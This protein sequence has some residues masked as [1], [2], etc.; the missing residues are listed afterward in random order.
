MFDA[1]LEDLIAKAAKRGEGGLP[2]ISIDSTTAS[3]HHQR[4][5]EA[6]I[7]EK[8]DHAANRKRKVPGVAGPSATTLTSARRGTP[9]NGR[10]TSSRHG[11]ASPLG[12]TRPRTD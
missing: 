4:H 10:S 6:V 11:G 8:G 1:L 2:L 5:I 9:S 12:T 3:A 7:P